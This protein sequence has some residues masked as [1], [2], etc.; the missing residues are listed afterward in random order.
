[1]SFCCPF[2]AIY[3]IENFNVVIEGGRNLLSGFWVPV[4]KSGVPLAVYRSLKMNPCRR[5]QEVDFFTP[6]SLQWTFFV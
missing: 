6:E 3:A 2:F 1:V 4:D 5:F